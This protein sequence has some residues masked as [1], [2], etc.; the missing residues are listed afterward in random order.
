MIADDGGD[1]EQVIA[2]DGGDC[3]CDSLTKSLCVNL[4][5]FLNV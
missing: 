4:I 2:V 5:L 1:C 3:D